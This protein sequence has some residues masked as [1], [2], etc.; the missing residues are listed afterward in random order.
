MNR[1]QILPPGRELIAIAVFA[2]LT[3][4]IMPW[5]HSTGAIAGH[6]LELYGKYLCYASLAVSLNLLWGYTGLL[7]LG[8]CLFFALGGYAFGMHLMLKIGID[9]V[10]KSPLPDFM[11]FQGYNKLPLHWVPFDSFPFAA[12]ATICVPALVALIFGFLVFRSRITGVYFAIITQALTYAAWILFLRNEFTFGGNNG[13]TKFNTILGAPVNAP[14]TERTLF[15]LSA[16]LLVG[17][18][19][20]C[21]VLTRT[22]F[23]KVQ[24]A[25]RDSENRVRFSGYC[26]ENFKLFIFTLSA[27]IAGVAGALYVPQAG[28]INPDVMKPVESLEVV[29]WVAVG[30]RATVWGPVI[31]A[32]AVNM[33]KSWA[34]VAF[35]DY[36]L[37][38]LGGV[39]LLVVLFLPGG[40]TSLVSK[41]IELKKSRFP[42][43]G[44][45][46]SVDPAE[47][48]TAAAS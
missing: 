44:S 5:M 42:T 4:L 16:L 25:I 12:A 35:P 19:L 48:E 15:I 43:A 27:A 11:D 17:V 38:I 46:P 32:L 7:C 2:I 20:L 34:T 18:I 26:T 10:Y 39:F 31:G 41:L 45:P 23:G 28:I 1:S 33:L 3:V 14:G 30:G 29:V 8:Q 13:F 21:T 47:P 40:L 36:W 22:R 9:P 24:K 6:K 37:I